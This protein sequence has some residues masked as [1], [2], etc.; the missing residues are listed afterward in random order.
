M[1]IPNFILLDYTAHDIS[2]V[3][4][5]ISWKSYYAKVDHTMDN[6]GRGFSDTAVV[7]SNIIADRMGYRGEIGLNIGANS[8]MFVGVD[9]YRILKDGNR[10][11]VMIGQ[12]RP[13]MGKVPLKHEDLWNNAVIDNYGF[14][15]EYRW[16]KEKW[17]VVGAMRLDYNMASSRFNFFNEYGETTSGFNWNQG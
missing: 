11:K 7:V 1:I 5:T 14:F 8:H 15:T 3:I 2:D 10:D 9:G 4:K 17:E 13:M 16:N 6:L 12:P